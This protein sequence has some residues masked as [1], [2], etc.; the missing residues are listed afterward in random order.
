RDD[1][2]AE[3]KA[4][5]VKL[6][7]DNEETNNNP[8]FNQRFQKMSRIPLFWFRIYVRRQS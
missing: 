7:D 3:L 4:E 5:I 2:I 6:R 8:F 1:A